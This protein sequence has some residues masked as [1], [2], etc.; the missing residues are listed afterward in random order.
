MQ[1]PESL[2]AENHWLV[3]D[4]VIEKVARPHTMHGMAGASFPFLRILLYPDE[5]RHLDL[6]ENHI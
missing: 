6:R 5:Y 4:V 1:A 2:M 3:E